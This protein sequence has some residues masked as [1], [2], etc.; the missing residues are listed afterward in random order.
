MSRKEIVRD[1]E[2]E[3]KSD[4]TGRTITVKSSDVPAPVTFTIK[5]TVDGKPYSKT[6]SGLDLHSTEWEW[7]RKWAEMEDRSE[8]PLLS[9]FTPV[10]ATANGSGGKSADARLQHIRAWAKSAGKKIGAQGRIPA[11]IKAEYD[12][13]KPEGYIPESAD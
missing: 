10:K 9:G 2:T 12:A 13:A 8:N 7:L 6:V 1:P 5:G 4:V 3:I 11:A